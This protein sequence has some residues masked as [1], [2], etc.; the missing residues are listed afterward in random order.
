MEVNEIIKKLLSVLPD[1]EMHDDKCWDWC[2]EELSDK[3]QE[4]VKEA[5]GIALK[6]LRGEEDEEV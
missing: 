2:W 6:Y 3:A 4:E 5:R 1:S